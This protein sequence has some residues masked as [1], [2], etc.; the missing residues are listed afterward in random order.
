[1]RILQLTPHFKPNMGGVETHLGDLVESLVARQNQVFVLTYRPI[2]TKA[3]WRISE[4]R[5]KLEILRIPWV[6]GLFYKLIHYPVLEFLYLFPGLFFNNTI[7]FG[8]KTN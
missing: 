5:G 8:N 3:S 7:C 1:M 6:P 4:K 2:T